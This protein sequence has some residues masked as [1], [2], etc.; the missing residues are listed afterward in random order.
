MED[1]KGENMKIKKTKS[2]LNSEAALKR[3]LRLMPKEGIA[4]NYSYINPY[5]E[6]PD[7]ALVIRDLHLNEVLWQD[8]LRR[9]GITK[10]KPLKGVTK[11]L[12]KAVR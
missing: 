8:S 7:I 9:L 10:R 6:S 3:A 12:R 11:R 1:K 4:F 5:D 2:K